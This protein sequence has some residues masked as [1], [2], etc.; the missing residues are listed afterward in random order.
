MVSIGVFQMYPFI[1]R[2]LIVHAKKPSSFMGRQLC[3]RGTTHIRNR[4]ELRALSGY[5][6]IP[7]L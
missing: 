2:L 1:L 4:I 7:A 5:R 6:H 3:H